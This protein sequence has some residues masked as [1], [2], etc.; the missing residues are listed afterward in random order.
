MRCTW[1]RPFWAG[2]VITFFARSLISM[3]SKVSFWGIESPSGSGQG[4]FFLLALGVTLPLASSACCAADSATT[5]P[6]ASLSKEWSTWSAW[7]T[8]YSICSIISSKPDV[9]SSMIND[10]SHTADSWWEASRTVF[11]TSLQ[12]GRICSRKFVVTL[13]LFF[14]TPVTPSQNRFFWPCP[15]SA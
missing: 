1:W 15:M 5:P 4:I 7:S 8:A 12:S 13:T 6:L 11:G 10:F 3:V 14:R 9:S 2:G